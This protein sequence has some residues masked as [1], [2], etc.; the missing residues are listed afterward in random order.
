MHY[1]LGPQKTKHQNSCT[2]RNHWLYVT[3]KSN[4]HSERYINLPCMD[5]SE[6][7]LSHC[8]PVRRK[9]IKYYVKTDLH[10][11]KPTVICIYDLLSVSYKNITNE[12]Y[13]AFKRGY[14]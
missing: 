12:L 10:L 14:S 1:S 6:L 3:Y 5:L 9:T 13:G 11:L 2:T 8:V 4:G 7:K